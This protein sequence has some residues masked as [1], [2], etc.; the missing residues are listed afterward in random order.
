MSYANAAGHSKAQHRPEATTDNGLIGQAAATAVSVP[1]AAQHNLAP[2]RS[3]K[4]VPSSLATQ[5]LQLP[6]SVLNPAAGVAARGHAAAESTSPETAAEAGSIPAR[7][8]AASIA[9]LSKGWSAGSGLR[10]AEVPLTKALVQCSGTGCEDVLE[11]SKEHRQLSGRV[12]QRDTWVSRSFR[13]KAQSSCTLQL[14]QKVQRGVNIK[15]GSPQHSLSMLCLH[16]VFIFI[17]NT[18]MLVSGPNKQ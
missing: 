7:T 18:C 1:T 4:P 10:Q 14:L 9:N 15:V 11:M 17:L 12:R 13:G 5:L 6:S 3:A 8:P 16:A 2:A